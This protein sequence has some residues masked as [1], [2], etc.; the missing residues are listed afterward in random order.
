M[1]VNN[2]PPTGAATAPTVKLSERMSR[3]QF[4]SYLYDIYKCEGG[5]DVTA[6]ALYEAEEFYVEVFS[7]S[8]V[9]MMIAI[10]HGF[11]GLNY[12]TVD[13]YRS[14]VV[15]SP[16]EASC[17]TAEQLPGAAWVPRLVVTEDA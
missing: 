2:M 4:T 7:D 15:Q 5:N 12:Q 1:P 3:R 8:P 13:V 16:E 9:G 17:V 14:A 10:H 6:D 11:A